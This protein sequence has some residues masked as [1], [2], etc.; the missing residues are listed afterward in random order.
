MEGGRGWWDGV[1]EG[2]REGVWGG[3]IAEGRVEWR[4]RGTLEREGGRVGER[5][6]GR[7]GGRDGRMK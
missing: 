4:D 7:E 1:I 6:G 5:V 2:Q 3:V